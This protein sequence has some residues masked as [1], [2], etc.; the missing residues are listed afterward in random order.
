[1]NNLKHFYEQ[2]EVNPIEALTDDLKHSINDGNK[3]EAKKIITK[4]K[5]ME[6]FRSSVSA[7]IGLTS[8][9]S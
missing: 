5:L 7:S 6:C 9:C 1:M 8:A 3:P 4:L 2:A